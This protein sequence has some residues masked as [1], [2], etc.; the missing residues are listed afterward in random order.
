MATKSRTDTA[1]IFVNP[2]PLTVTLAGL[3]GLVLACLVLAGCPSPPKLLYGLEMV[4]KVTGGKA[5]I[6][7][8][9]GD[10]CTPSSQFRLLYDT[11]SRVDPTEYVFQTTAVSGF[12]EN[13]PINFDLTSLPGNTRIYYRVAIDTGSGWMYRDEYTFRTKRPGGHSFRFCMASDAHV[14]QPPLAFTVYRA[15]TYA[16]V[17]ADN[18]DLFFALGDEFEVSGQGP[19]PY[20]LLGSQQTV[21]ATLQRYRGVTDEAC[22]STSCL[23]VNGNHEGLFGWTSETPQYQWIREAK[24]DYFPVPDS[25]TFPQGGDDDGRYGAFRWGDVLFVWL[26][27]VGFCQTDPWPAGDNQYY[28]LG[29]AQRSFL[30][31]TLANS[32][33]RWKFIFSHHLFGGVEACGLGYGRGNANGAYLHD[34]ADIQNMMVQSG[35]QAFFYGHDHVF[36]VSE[37]DGVSYIATGHAGG[38]GG[39]WTELL[40]SCYEPYLIFPTDDGIV[41]AGHVRVDVSHDEATVSYI[42]A[43]RESDNRSVIA[44]YVLTP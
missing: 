28:V 4:G 30:Q 26:D 19:N 24:L 32:T 39:A 21:Y 15:L 44:S 10:A 7:L 35:A 31:T 17:A 25:S 23:F 37:A 9:A 11:T 40:L 22:H 2:V 20:L 43:S 38:G 12:S 33:A 14:R 27:V 41:P 1:A 42:R 8:V 6:R 3:I 36:S 18:P 29:D 34:Q 13:D 16:N 5:T